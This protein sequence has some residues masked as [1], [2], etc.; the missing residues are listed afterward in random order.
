MQGAGCRGLA[1]TPFPAGS[2]AS[3]PAWQAREV[4][5]SKAD[6]RWTM[7]GPPG[8]GFSTP[9]PSASRESYTCHWVIA[10]ATAMAV[11]AGHRPAGR[12]R[13]A[14]CRADVQVAGDQRGLGREA[15]SEGCQ[16]RKP[17]PGRK[18]VTSVPGGASRAEIQR[19]G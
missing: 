9:L 11:R 7:G 12:N 6:G 4:S 15:G 2:R 8:P 3:K 13:E 18:L 16:G 19:A 5:A 17:C 1:R 14:L 10:V